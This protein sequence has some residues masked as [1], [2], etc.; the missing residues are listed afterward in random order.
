MRRI[1]V[2]DAVFAKTSSLQ[3]ERFGSVLRRSHVFDDKFFEMIDR[4]RADYEKLLQTILFLQIPTTAYL[5]LVLA[6]VDVNL[7]I[8]G[9][10]AGKNLRE[11][12]VIVAS[13]LGL[14]SAYVRN[15]KSVIENMLHAR[16]ERM[17]KGDAAIL[18][19]IKAGYGLSPFIFEQPTNTLWSPS[20]LRILSLF[21]FVASLVLLL[22]FIAGA[23]LAVHVLTLVEIY[24]HPNFS[25]LATEFTI[26]F[27]I[28]ADAV[29]L[30]WTLAM[31]GAIPYRSHERI[32][33]YLKLREQDPEAAQ[34]IMRRMVEL[35]L[36]RPWLLRIITRPKLPKDF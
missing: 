13:G 34:A 20:I 30:C 15:Q 19:F 36:K 14:W 33:R 31:S 4:R 27:V 28:V 21:L 29:S 23:T 22:I 26:S 12:L 5:V 3:I 11:V 7:S 9:I 32:S 25:R 8:L 35:H 17:A 10:A 24:H 1:K 2:F 16:A 6:G 18:E